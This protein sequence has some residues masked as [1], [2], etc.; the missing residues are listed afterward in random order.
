MGFDLGASV[1]AAAD[2]VSRAPVVGA[3]VGNPVFTALLIVALAAVVLTATLGR[4][5]SAARPAR[6]TRAAVYTFLLVLAVTFVHHSVVTREARAAVEQHGVRS[7]FAGIEQIRRGGFPSAT[8]HPAAFP[9][10]AGAYQGAPAGAY[11]GAPAGAY[12]GMP[13]AAYQGAPAGAYQ[14]MPGAAYQGAPGA[15]QG[16]VTGGAVCSTAGNAASCGWQDRRDNVAPLQLENVT[17]P[18]TPS[19]FGAPAPSSAAPSLAAPSLA[20]PA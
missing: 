9:G 1:N 12:Q 20:A 17:V 8:S 18:S 10:A 14:G 16:A 4:A 7:V 2:W 13:S 5:L 11:Q 6:K 15:H 3:I 19:P